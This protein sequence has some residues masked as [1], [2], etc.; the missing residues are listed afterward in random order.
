MTTRIVKKGKGLLLA[1]AGAFMLA[2]CDSI[3][4]LPNNY[5]NEVVI[6]TKDGTKA[7]VYNNIMGTLYDDVISNKKDDV[8]NNFINIIA[9]DQFGKYSDIKKLVTENN[10]S[11]IKSFIEQHMGIYAH[12]NKINDNQTEDDYLAEKYGISVDEIRSERLKA[13][14]K[15][16]TERINK[17]FYDEITSNTYNDDTGKFFE[18]RLA[19]AHYAE[20][21]DIDMSKSEWFEGYITPELEKENVSSFIHLDDGRYEDYIERNL[22]KSIY[23]DKLVEQYL[24]ENNYSTLGRAYGRKVNIIKLTRDEKF[25][26]LPSTL[27]NKYADKYI[28]SNSSAE[29]DFNF[30]SDCWKGFKGIDK[31]GNVIELTSDEKQLLKDCGLTELTYG[32][33][34]YFPETQFGQLIEKYSKIDQSNRFADEEATSALSEFTGSYTYTKEKGL[35][36]K[37]AELANK[38]YTT[39]GWYVKNGGLTDLPSSIRDRLFNI[40]VSNEIDNM[41][42]EGSDHK[43]S[44]SQ[45]VRYI[46]GHYYLT[47]ATSESADDDPRN[48]VIYD[49]DSFYIVEVVE[50][51][52]TSKLDMDGKNSYVSKRNSEG[53][54][55]TET[56]ARKLAETLGTKDS[57]V[58]KTYSSYIEKYSVSYHDSSIYD[59]FKEKYPE[60]FE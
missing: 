31:D 41:E 25:K 52:S 23:K 14:Y 51:V 58:N 7:D 32:S 59:Y 35:K 57:Y 33:Y 43:Y 56:V 2:G 11:N 21:Y 20:L 45:Y 28:L 38:D 60:L 16:V 37:L 27:L 29:I 42:Q 46:N 30:I 15:D 53:A 10:A 6:S 24:L 22:I 9:E 5:Q 4:A 18:R 44:S 8:L 13:F 26:D 54:L 1:L 48:F 34:K 50:A 3:Q 39:D 40:T 19:M 12:D 47:P 36:I 49:S 55:F 17:A